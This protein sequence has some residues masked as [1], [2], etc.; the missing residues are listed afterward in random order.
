MLFLIGY[1]LIGACLRPRRPGGM[2]SCQILFILG[3]KRCGTRQLKTLLMQ[4]PSVYAP[5]H[6]DEIRFFDR[7]TDAEHF[8]QLCMSPFWG[9]NK[10][11]EDTAGAI[12]YS[13]AL[14]PGARGIREARLRQYPV[15]SGQVGQLSVLSGVRGRHSET[16]AGCQVNC[17][18]QRSDKAGDLRL[19]L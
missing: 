6:S 11:D 2:L 3:G 5:E 1:P 15:R 19:L 17:A 13:A 18:P 14:Q 8:S 10:T 16:D 12:H 9:L 7:W 4:H